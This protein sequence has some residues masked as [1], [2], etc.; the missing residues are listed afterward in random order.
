MMFLNLGSCYVFDTWQILSYLTA[1]SSP[2][3]YH[4]STAWNVLRESGGVHGMC[5]Q[6]QQ[7]PLEILILCAAL[8]LLDINY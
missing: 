4:H 2:P 7:S 8:I 5:G 3:S 1:S 6:T